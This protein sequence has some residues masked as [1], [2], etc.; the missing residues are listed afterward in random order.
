MIER[1]MFR[2]SD[3]IIEAFVAHLKD[4]YWHTFP[5]G[6]QE[7]SDAISKTARMV[8]PHIAR[9]NAPYHDLSHTILVAQIGQHLLKG[10]NLQGA[11]VSSVDWM[12]FVISTLCFAVGFVRNVCPGDD[13][14]NSCVVSADGK[15]AVVP[16]G[17][18]DG[19]LWPYFTDRSKIFV[20]HHFRSDPLLDWKILS[21]NIEYSRFPPLTDRNLETTTYPGLLRAA[22]LIGAV[23]DPDFVLKSKPLML[24]LE[25]SG[26]ASLLGFADVAAFQLGF[27]DMFW[28]TIFPLVA[29]GMRLLNLTGEGRELLTHL[30][31]HLLIE[32]PAR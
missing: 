31:A 10:R 32:Q 14:K 20:A 7:H 24:E 19:W 8:L 28:K 29:G 16:R 30:H 1:R 18:T 26:M 17:A 22:H 5:G 12:H 11:K 25:E 23:A 27:R 13:G 6:A 4:E 15:M 21:A 3:I 9:S 2:P